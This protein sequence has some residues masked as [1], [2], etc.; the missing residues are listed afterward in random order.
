MNK[1][2]IKSMCLALLFCFVLAT[3]IFVSS[4]SVNYNVNLYEGGRIDITGN[5][6]SGAGKQIT[7]LVSKSNVGISSSTIVFIDQQATTTNGTFLFRFTLPSAL[8]GTT[9]DFKIGG[10][11]LTVSL[12]KTLTIPDFPIN[13]NSVEN[14]SVR[15]GVDAYQMESSYYIADNVVN[16]IIE[17]GNTIYYKIG[18]RWYNL[19]DTRATSAEFLIPANAVNPTTVSAWLLDTWYP[20]GGFGSMKFDPILLY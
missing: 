7:L 3:P 17:G 8:R 1:I 15:V 11:D 2:L 9:L 10:E 20:R 16:S 6:S 5:L 12:Q 13:I 14:N 18:D 19:L 4:S